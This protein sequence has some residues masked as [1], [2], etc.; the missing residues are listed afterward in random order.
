MA[1]YDLKYASYVFY[2]DKTILKNIPKIQAD[3]LK[4][5]GKNSIIT[6]P[7]I[8]NSGLSIKKF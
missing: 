4:L 3:K 7:H 8:Y 2:G 1:N 5:R 6:L